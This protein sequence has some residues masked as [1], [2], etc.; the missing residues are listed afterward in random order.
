ME[1]RTPEWYAARIGKVGASEIGKIVNK[2][3]DGTPFQQEEDLLFQKVT[4]RLT[5]KKT[6]FFVNQA[7]QDGIDR[8]PDA[9]EL[10]SLV[11]KNNVEEVG[12]IPH[13]TI[14]DT[15]ASPDG[16]IEVDGKQG[17][18]EIKCPADTTHTKYLLDKK[19][20]A[21]YYPQ[22]QFQ[23]ACTKSDFA[24]FVSYNPNFEPEQQ[25]MWVLVEKDEEYIAKIEKT[26]TE[27][28][29]KVDELVNEIKEK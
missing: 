19:C 13:P 17:V 18:L 8:E 21:Q 12:F 5:G 3:K 20:P 11:T 28:L 22:I 25:M 4:E 10:Y 9:R 1:Q 15:G 14:K 7:M 2:K 16:M 29:T 26:V 23:M 6:D 27:F 24:H